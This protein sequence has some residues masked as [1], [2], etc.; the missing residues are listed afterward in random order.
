MPWM[1]SLFACDCPIFECGPRDGERRGRYARPAWCCMPAPV[2]DG[3]GAQ[4]VTIPKSGYRTEAGD[5]L[6]LS[7]YD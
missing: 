2:S 4:I 7:I 1:V 5:G 6:R 3:T